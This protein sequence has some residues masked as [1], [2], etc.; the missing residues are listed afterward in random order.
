MSSAEFRTPAADVRYRDTVY[1]K[2]DCLINSG[3]RDNCDAKV[4]GTIKATF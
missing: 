1:S 2:T 4:V 3:A